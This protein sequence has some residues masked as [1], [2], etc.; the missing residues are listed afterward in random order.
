[1]GEPGSSDGTVSPSNVSRRIT[2]CDYRQKSKKALEALPVPISRVE[3]FLGRRAYRELL[4]AA[5]QG[6]AVPAHDLRDGALLPAGSLARGHYM[7]PGN[8]SC[9]LRRMAHQPAICQWCGQ[10]LPRAC[11]RHHQSPH[12][13]REEIRHHFHAR[14]WTARLLAIPVIFGH[15]RPTAFLP[16]RRKGD[17]QS[18]HATQDDATRDPL[19]VNVCRSSGAARWLKRR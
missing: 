2:M 13:H 19:L 15:V 6:R 16:G 1:M 4:R 14:C 10:R 9:A 5:R 11:A 18:G 7:S 3:Q 8:F 12:D 17:S